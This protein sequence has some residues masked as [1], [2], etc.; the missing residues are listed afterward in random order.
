MSIKYK[1]AD[2]KNK[3]TVRL[4]EENVK[5][6]E[7]KDE[8]LRKKLGLS[9]PLCP[10]RSLRA[11]KPSKG[12]DIKTTEQARKIKKTISNPS[13]TDDALSKQMQKKLSEFTRKTGILTLKEKRYSFTMNDFQL[14]CVIGSGTCGEVSKMKHKPT[15]RVLAVKKMCQSYNAEE[16]KRIVMDLDVV[17]KSHD[18]PYIVECFGAYISESDVFIIMQLMETCFDKLKN[19]YGPIPERILGKMTVAVVKA[20]HYLKESH[21]VMHRDVKPS[22]ILLDSRGCVKLCDFGISGRLVDSKAKTRSAG[23]AAYMAPERIDPPDPSNPD[24]DV[25]ADVWSLGIS[26]VE[27]ASGKFPYDHCK[28]EFEI[29]TRIIEERS[30]ALPTDKGFSM[31][32]QSFVT[33]CLHKDRENRPKYPSLL[34][35]EFIKTSEKT[36]VNVGEWLMP[37]STSV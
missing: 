1:M 36:V 34:K 31:E 17:L 16:Q 35:E 4:D 24:Y 33:Q 11:R 22:N 9:L 23:C 10:G 21:G 29:L 13:K 12:L 19:T 25:R 30:P 26:L 27:L 7:K 2:N 6:D 8:K 28:N 5:S 20:L 3:K 37:G 32:F 18:C 14:I 15:G